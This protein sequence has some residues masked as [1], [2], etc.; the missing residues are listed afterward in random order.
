M[1]TFIMS[2]ASK[3]SVRGAAPP[4]RLPPRALEA[5]SGT[6]LASVVER[7]RWLGELDPVLRQSLPAT[8]A[9]QCKL[10]NVD[11]KNLVF[12]VSAPVWKARLRLHADA[13]LDAAA[14]AGLKART[15]VV[16]VAPP[17]PAIPA[18][19][20]QSKPLS[21]AVRDSLRAT[22]QSVS[23]PGLR[24]QLL[25]LAGKPRSTTDGA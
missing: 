12:L 21:E 1:M 10:A 11:D 25:R 6:G 22:A 3:P 2:D 4:T 7:A 5:L 13:L 8:L 14:A 24:A 15:L 9:D 23:D 19:T 20:G 16:K 17:E 18:G